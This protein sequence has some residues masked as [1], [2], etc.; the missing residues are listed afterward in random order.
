MPRVSFSLNI[1]PEQV[2]KYYRGE[3]LS[4]IATTESGLKVQFPANLILPHVTHNSIHGRFVLEY[5][6]DG[7]AISLLRT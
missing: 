3:A 7:K 5:Q 6:N 2:Q 4:V 1:E